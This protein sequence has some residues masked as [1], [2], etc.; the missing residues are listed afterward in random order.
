M[1]PNS[2]NKINDSSY[3]Y[4]GAD[5]KYSNHSIHPYPAVMIPQIVCS[6]LKNYSNGGIVL[7]PFCGSGTTLLEAKLSNN[8]EKA[9]GIDIN[10]LAC[11]ISKVKTT[12]VNPKILKRQYISIIRKSEEYKRTELTKPEVYHIDY[13]FKDYVIDK[14]S[15]IKNA[16]YEIKNEDVKDFFK[17]V[18]SSIIRAVSNTRNNEFKLYRMP[19][20]KLKRFHPD[21]YNEFNIAFHRNY[22]KM[23]EFYKKASNCTINVLYEDS[24]LKTSIDKES[25]DLILTSP[26]YGD[27]RTTVAYGQFSRLS[28]QWLGYDKN[29][30]T[31]LDSTLLGGRRKHQNNVE[32]LRSQTLR[33]TLNKISTIDKKR[34]QDVFSYFHDLDLCINEFDRVVKHGS[35]LCFVV[36]NRTVKG[37]T[38]PTDR[39]LCELFLSKND[40]YEHEKTITRNISSKHMPRA[41]S[42][43][44][45]KKKTSLTI[46]KENV[47]IIRK[48]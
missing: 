30:T 25:I 39:I 2:S 38:I 47:I 19:E 43:T 46:N 29:V 17:V 23:I 6:L 18:F 8:Y 7:D 45:K 16:I 24:R 44:N 27:S 40:Y 31:S 28:L 13:W 32:V 20:S 14:L 12:Q 5:T 48:K 3:D 15:R 34:C 36:G 42:P 1:Q 35:Y 4:A 21:V 26:P 9:I 33:E 10:P 22:L 11:L 41:N 37:V